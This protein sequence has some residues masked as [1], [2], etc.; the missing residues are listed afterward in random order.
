[1]LARKFRFRPH[2]FPRAAMPGLALALGLACLTNAP[3]AN[4]VQLDLEGTGW[5]WF[6]TQGSSWPIAI[7]LRDPRFGDGTDP[8][9]PA[10]VSVRVVSNTVDSGE[11][12]LQC[13]HWKASRH[14]FA[15]RGVRHGRKKADRARL[16][17]GRLVL[18]LR[19]GAMPPLERDP[20]FVEVRLRIDSRDYCGRFEQL[21]TRRRGVTARGTTAP[22]REIRPPPNILLIN[23]DDARHDGIDLMPRVQQRL[24]DEGVRF[25][26]SFTPNPVCCPSRA[27][28]FSGLYALNHRV[29]QV[30]GVIGGARVFREE[31]RDQHTIAVWLQQAGYRT[32]LFGKYLNAYWDDTEG[33][34]G[35]GG[36]FYR[37]PG[38]DRWWAMTSPEHYGGVYGISYRIVEE[39]GA[40]TLFDGH[41][42]DAQYSTDLSAEILRDFVS[43]AVEEGRPFFAYWA[44]YA[45]HVERPSFLPAPAER[46]FGL[47]QSLAKWRPPSWNEP[48]VDDKPRWIEPPADAFK[49]AFTDL[50][51]T[52][53]YETL[54]S[55]DE[56]VDEM[57]NQLDRLEVSRDTVV[58]LTSDN[59]VG[60][61]EHRIF[62]TKKG[63][64]YEECQRV[65]MIVRYPRRAPSREVSG[66]SVLNI[67]LAPTLA[68]LAGAVVPTPIDGRSFAG[69]LEG[70]KDAVRDDYLME[71]WRAERNSHLDLTTRPLDGDRVR[72]LVGDWRAVPRVGVSF[73]FDSGNGTAPG[74]VPVPIGRSASITARNLQVRIAFLIPNVTPRVNGSRVTVD[75][76]SAE[77]HGV[78]W[79][80]EVDQAGSLEPE[81]DTPDYFGVRDVLNGY[82]WVEYETGEHELYDLRVDPDQLENL[83]NDSN[84]ATVRKRLE[85]RLEALLEAARNVRD[86]LP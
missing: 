48:D 18:R 39:N 57:L 12:R 26:H 73:E 30:A 32:G 80:E 86:R 22:C 9:C 21:T 85:Q 6:P 74:T 38:W 72:L 55:V 63:C 43:A 79:W 5:A 2:P 82:T 16:A 59:G 65:P 17:R 40:I 11:V 13:E 25:R 14:G 37:P 15:Y 61:G 23:L 24:G 20:D 41:S 64:P 56:Q 84:Y 50:M 52:R 3:A 7:V 71:Y 45:P 28:V 8:R 60:W 69:W 33:S 58:V 35:P 62:F 68:E 76:E 51:R 36:T 31:G 77:H 83:A 47:F 75:D 53:G 1:M 19:S 70:R 67:D 29:R 78:Y 49:A 54:L 34:A 66:T 27:S 44:P 46:H 81:N 4:A 10:K 42:S